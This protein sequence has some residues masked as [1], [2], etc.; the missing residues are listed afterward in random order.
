VR[1]NLRFR[2]EHQRLFPL[3]YALISY[4]NIMWALNRE[5]HGKTGKELGNRTSGITGSQWGTIGTATGLKD[6]HNEAGLTE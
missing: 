5:E 3:D 6:G 1:P 2:S 4:R